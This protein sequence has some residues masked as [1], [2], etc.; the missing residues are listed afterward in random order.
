MIKH[1]VD[2]FV[3]SFSF[4]FFNLKQILKNK[5][6]LQRSQKN[7][8]VNRGIAIMEILHSL[9]LCYTLSHIHPSVIFFSQ[10]LV[11]SVYIVILM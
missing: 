6:N 10:F 2:L 1:S 4:N 3:Y 7:C 5:N 9:M 8:T 11:K